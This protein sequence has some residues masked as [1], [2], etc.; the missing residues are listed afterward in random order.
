[1]N[2]F[3]IKIWKGLCLAFTLNTILLVISPYLSVPSHQIIILAITWIF[4]FIV[5]LIKIIEPKKRYHLYN[6][7]DMD[8]CPLL[9]PILIFFFLLGATCQ[10]QDDPMTRATPKPGGGGIS[11]R[12]DSVRKTVWLNKNLPTPARPFNIYGAL[13]TDGALSHISGHF[14]GEILID[15]HNF[16][17]LFG[18]VGINQASLAWRKKDPKQKGPAIT[19][20]TTF[21]NAILNIAKS[22][23]KL[24]R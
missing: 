19:P 6:R 9:Y 14:G 15:T 7:T 12:L 24:F 16:I 8:R 2:D 18:E 20:S 3:R 4:T 13:G 11:K 1:M 21:F 23:E 10:A 5:G 22:V 17:Y